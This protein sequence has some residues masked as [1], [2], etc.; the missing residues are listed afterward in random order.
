MDFVHIVDNR[1]VSASLNNL[2]GDMMRARSAPSRASGFTFAKARREEKKQSLTSPGPIYAGYDVHN[3][4]MH[5]SVSIPKGPRSSV[6]DQI[7]CVSPGPAAPY[8][9][10]NLKS[11]TSIS[12]PKAKRFADEEIKFKDTK[13]TPGRY[14]QVLT[15]QNHLTNLNCH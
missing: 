15:S 11:K 14:Q 1:N 13:L 7:T 6:F 10:I 4:I 2:Y 3:N 8:N 9:P 12:F 5:K